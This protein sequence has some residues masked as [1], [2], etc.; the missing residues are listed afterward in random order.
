M[1]DKLS[2]LLVDE[3]IDFRIAIAGY[4]KTAMELGHSEAK[5]LKDLVEMQ[6]EVIEEN[7]NG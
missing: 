2:P 5:I 3:K 7:K 1:I 6:E 4:V